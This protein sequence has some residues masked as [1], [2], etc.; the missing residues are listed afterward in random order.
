M[1]PHSFTLHSSTLSPLLYQHTQ[2]RYP[3]TPHALHT[4]LSQAHA[5]PSTR[6][7]VR[8]TPRPPVSAC[9]PQERIVAP[10]PTSYHAALSFDC[11]SLHY[12]GP[13]RQPAAKQDAAPR[14]T[15]SPP[16]SRLNRSS[17]RAHIHM[18]THRQ[19]FQH[20]HTTMSEKP[21][22]CLSV[23]PSFSSLCL[24]ILSILHDL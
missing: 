15:K 21:C 4:G 3:L 23:V 5:S 12:C 17:L 14:P 19:P 24:P 9:L 2:G 22:T 10:P 20:T 7:L 1:P 11:P 8:R 18:H 16:Q 13:R 6:K